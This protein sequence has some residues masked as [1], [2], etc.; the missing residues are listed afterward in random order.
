MMEEIV[1]QILNVYHGDTRYRKE[2]TGK[3][4]NILQS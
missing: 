4:N 1:L 3:K 2:N